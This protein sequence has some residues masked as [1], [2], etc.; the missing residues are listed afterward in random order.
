MLNIFCAAVS[1]KKK[2]TSLYMALKI[3]SNGSSPLCE[4]ASIC[5]DG[6]SGLTL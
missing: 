3:L 6:L 4:A 1:V 5:Q 2:P